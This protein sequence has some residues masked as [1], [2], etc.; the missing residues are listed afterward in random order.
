MNLKLL[1]KQEFTLN[2]I[3]NRLVKSRNPNNNNKFKSEL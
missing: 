1:P 2:H 3:I